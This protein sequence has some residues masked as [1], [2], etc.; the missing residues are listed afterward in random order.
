MSKPPI[1][2]GEPRDSLQD[3]RACENRRQLAVAGLLLG[4]AVVHVSVNRLVWGD[5]PLQTDTGMWAYIGMRI[6]E[7]AIPYRDLWESKPPGIYYTFA[8]VDGMFGRAAVQALVWLDAVVSLGVFLV[9]YR[10]ARRFASPAASGAAVLLLSL[11]FCHR[12]LADWGN[13]VE[14]FVA[15]FEMLA[16]LVALRGLAAMPVGSPSL[17]LRVGVPAGADSGGSGVRRAILVGALCGG[18][19]LFKQTGVAMLI[20]WLVSVSLWTQRGWLGMRA[21]STQWAACAAGVGIVWI[22]VVAY[23]AWAG[24]LSALVDQALL[25][26]LFRAG[27]GQLGEGNRLFTRGHWASLGENLWLGIVLLGPA[28]A[29]IVSNMQRR[30]NRDARAPGQ[31]TD[32]GV[33]LIVLYAGVALLPLILAPHGYGHYLLQAAPPLAVLAA[34]AVEQAL[35][36]WRKSVSAALGVA[37]VAVGCVSLKDHV[38]FTLRGDTENG[39]YAHQRTR[40][41]QLVEVMQDASRP[42]EAVMLWPPDYAAQFYARRRTPLEISNADVIFKDRIYRLQPPMESVLHRLAE[43]PPELII[44]G[45]GLKLAPPATPGGEPLLMVEAGVS[46]VEEPADQ[47][48]TIEGRMLAPLKRWL[49]SRYG[50]QTRVGRWTLYRRGEPWRDCMDYLVLPGSG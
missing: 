37:M 49:R 21:A 46:L 16:C 25:Y 9:T 19:L 7:G 31:N 33:R 28:L 38:A 35:Y 13:N 48:P 32:P 6:T 11:V 20:A 1:A 39:A 40:M 5:I 36:Q 29:G 4:L 12:V 41:Q 14:K 42:G 45:T 24:N 23:F 17:A 18:A 30:Q 10:V 44:D 50:G 15:L 22:P 2:A 8:A 26:D 47:H 27:G 34:V 43:N 3:P